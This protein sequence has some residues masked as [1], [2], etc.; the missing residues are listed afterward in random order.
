MTSTGPSSSPTFAWSRPVPG[1]ITATAVDELLSRLRGDVIT[2]VNASPVTVFY[3]DVPFY[4]RSLESRFRR[5]M[6]FSSSNRIWQR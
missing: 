4:H 2:E 1:A 6:T 3:G 5:A